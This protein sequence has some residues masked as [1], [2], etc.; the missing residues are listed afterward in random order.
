MY[1]NSVDR[2]VRFIFLVFHFENNCS[3]VTSHCPPYL[4]LMFD[5]CHCFYQQCQGSNIC[6]LQKNDCSSLNRRK[7]YTQKYIFIYWMTQLIAISLRVVLL[8]I[9]NVYCELDLY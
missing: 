2:P 8:F 4:L 1:K 5:D 6:L 3:S 9:F 7:C